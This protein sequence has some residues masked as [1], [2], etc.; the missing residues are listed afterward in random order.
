MIWKSIYEGLEV[1]FSKGGCVNENIVNDSL[2]IQARSSRKFNY[3][4]KIIRV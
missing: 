2:G 1:V 4:H 3:T